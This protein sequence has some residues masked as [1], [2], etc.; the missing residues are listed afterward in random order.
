MSWQGVLGTHAGFLCRASQCP[1]FVAQQHSTTLRLV[2]RPGEYAPWPS[3]LWYTV[4]F[5]QDRTDW[6][7]GF[8]LD[9]V[10]PFW[11]QLKRYP[12][13]LLPELG[14]APGFHVIPRRWVVERTF[15]WLGRQRRLSKDYER[16][17]STEEALI[18]LVGIRI[19]PARLAPA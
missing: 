10:S 4:F 13:D 18:Y 14:D 11:R 19:L 8:T 1:S 16:L 15:P 3:V 2:E 17:T 6:P 9:V 12:P 7:Y 5:R